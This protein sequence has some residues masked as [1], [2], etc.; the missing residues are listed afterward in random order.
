MED[1]KKNYHELICAAIFL[2]IFFSG[3]M[4]PPVGALTPTGMK[5][6]ALFA[7]SVIG[8]SVSKELWVSCLTLAFLPLTGVMNVMGMVSSTFGNNS[9]AS[10]IIAFSFT[11]LLLDTG[12]GDYLVSLMLR[13][14]WIGNHPWCMIA[15]LF[16]LTW[17]LSAMTNVFTGII[18]VWGL[19]YKL[20]DM[21]GCRPYEKLS[22]V[23]IFGVLIAGMLSTIATPWLP[24][25][26]VITGAFS[27]M[28]GLPI[29]YLDYML[30]S[31]PYSLISM[32]AF[33]VFAR[34]VFRPDVSGLKNIS[35]EGL[36]IQTYQ[37]S[38]KVR[39]SLCGF[40]VLIVCLL[41]PNIL[42]AGNPVR[43]F[44]ESLG[45]VGSGFIILSALSLIRTED[46]PVISMEEIFK[47][48]LPWKTLI[49][50]AAI[51]GLSSALFSESTGLSTFF[52]DLVVPVF[53]R[54]PKVLF[55]T[56]IALLGVILTNFMI[57]AIV[58]VALIVPAAAACANL[59]ISEYQV[60]YVICISTSM[61]LLTPPSGATAMLLHGNTKWITPK[62]IW[63][64]SVPTLLLFS[65]ILVVFSTIMV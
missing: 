4:I 35:L 59:G 13:P 60:L 9:F 18:L 38:N 65:V 57:N 55:I 16:I 7:A 17:L 19:V 6:I 25:I 34:V 39:I 26:L 23:L 49:M 31:I 3:W 36:G 20:C 50:T 30:V 44:F 1:V 28:T 45:L 58:A 22:T 2:V 54:L 43:S 51:L 8:W 15:A 48:Y 61:A 63:K 56:V 21:L 29:N 12:V 14:K 33:T 42:P 53:A 11:G 24:N 62:D 64:Y 41:M 32:A 10:L 46:G 47:N 27:N 37:S 40:F 52:G 5:V